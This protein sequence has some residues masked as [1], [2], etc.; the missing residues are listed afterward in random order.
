MNF[1]SFA[2]VTRVAVAALIVGL[3]LPAL[4][5]VF[6]DV[7]KDFV[8]YVALIGH[9]IQYGEVLVRLDRS[10]TATFKARDT[11]VLLIKARKGLHKV[12][13][14]WEKP[15]L[16]NAV[17][18]DVHD[19]QNIY[20]KSNSIVVLNLKNG[21]AHK[22]SSNVNPLYFDCSR[23]VDPS[24]GRCYQKIDTHEWREPWV[25]I[26]AVNKDEKEMKYFSEDEFYTFLS[27]IGF[28]PA[29]I[30]KSCDS[31]VFPK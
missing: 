21:A 16:T 30:E 2:V 22:S 23:G 14:Y 17:N 20:V 7:E 24:T 28:D 9:G 18:S 15:N 19:S 29:V 6:P 26:V 11:D 1:A 12:E 10:A 13:A 4:P 3:P 31:C 5:Q 8:G 27:G 25:E